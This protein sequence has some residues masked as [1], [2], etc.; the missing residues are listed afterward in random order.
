MKNKDFL[1]VYG[2]DVSPYNTKIAESQRNLGEGNIFV[3]RC[4]FTECK[5]S[6]N[7]GGI[8]VNSTDDTKMLVEKCAFDKCQV[9]T[10]EK[11]GA[12]YFGKKGNCIIF[13]VCGYECSTNEYGQFDYVCCTNN[14]AYKNYVNDSTISHSVNENADSTLAHFYGIVLFKGVNISFNRFISCSACHCAVTPS[15]NQNPLTCSLSFCS[16]ANNSATGSK[17]ISLVIPAANKEIK[18]CN[19]ID[20]SQEALEKFGIFFMFGPYVIK[21]SC[22]TGNVA[23]HTF[24]EV[25]AS[26]IIT[27]NN[28]TLDADIELENNTRVSFASKA[29]NLFTVP[30]F[31]LNTYKCE[32][33]M[34]INFGEKGTCSCTGDS[35]TIT[36]ITITS[37]MMS[38]TS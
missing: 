9:T 11:G 15:T 18:S 25:H 13:E 19:I 14:V 27:V 12:I 7:G 30:L 35:S 36:L 1:S 5:S 8:Y 3:F 21:D 26:F 34:T 4:Q 6:S 28:C 17:I 29:T 31:H 24:F 10:S 2:T 20:N 37:F 32:A 33:E 22:I 38:I 23:N 16:F